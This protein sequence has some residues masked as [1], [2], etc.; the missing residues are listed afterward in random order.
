MRSGNAGKTVTLGA[1]P[2]LLEKP[3]GARA[4]VVGR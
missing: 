4:E 1:T 2:A 3:A